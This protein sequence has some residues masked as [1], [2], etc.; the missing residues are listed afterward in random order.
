MTTG[1][2]YDDGTSVGIGTTTLSEALTVNG[3]VEAEEFI[4]D[5]RGAVVFKAN[6]GEDISKGEAVYISGIS[7]NKTVVS[8]ADADDAS[9][10]P[11][12]G[13]A[14]ETASS[15]SDITIV[16]FGRINNLDT[17]SYTEGEELFVSTTAGEL[18]NTPPAGES[19]LLQK[20]AKVTRS[21][22]S[23][24]SMTVMGAGRTNAVPNLNQ[25]SL[26]VGNSS[27]Q[28]VADDTLY[29]DIVNTGV[30]INNTSPSYPLHV[31]GRSASAGD[32]NY[33]AYFKASTATG[34]SG[35][36]FIAIGS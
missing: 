32:T 29:V 35:G 33:A 1:V 7:G 26:F 14:A 11:A 9:K 16:T 19:A 36:T 25:G 18:T 30:G 20:L 34:P 17:S 21:D 10:M 23:A 5:L 28:A 22:N 15:G 8:L 2:I 13:I 12:F 31:V 6:A 27:N 3:R 24:G 4:G